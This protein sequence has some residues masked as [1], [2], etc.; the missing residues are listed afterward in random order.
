MKLSI[1]IPAYNEADNIRVT[2]EELLRT[3]DKIAMIDEIKLVVVDDH[4]S[5]DTFHVVSEANDPRVR[6]MRLSRR[7]GAHTAIRAGLKEADGDATL[8]IDADGQDDP[9]ILAR[10]VEKWSQG[11]HTVWAVRENREDE[12]WHIKGPAQLFYKIMKWLSYDREMNIDLSRA[13]FY[14]LDRTVVSAVNACRERNTSLFGLIV[15]LGFN[16]G[17]VEYKRRFRRHGKSKWNFKSRLKLA[18]DWI[19]AFSGIPLKIASS[20]GIVTA[21]LGVVYAVIVIMNRLMFNIKVEG[22]ATIVVF[23]LVLGG[24]QLTML[25]I[26]GEYL[27]RNLEESRNRPMFFIEKRSDERDRT[28]GD[29]Q[30]ERPE[31]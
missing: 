1:V 30:E 3:A 20:L 28:A 15:W 27:W 6:C 29:P 24:L 4:S 17:F 26:M 19:V 18:S 13:D 25:G 22:F 5:D 14:L 2:V 9:A 21:I 12:P 23:I 8:C 16:Q 11:S 10:M 7:S 31:R